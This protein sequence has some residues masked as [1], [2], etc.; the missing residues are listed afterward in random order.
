MLFIPGGSSAELQ[1][2][3]ISI[4][5]LL[6]HLIKEQAMQFFAESVCRDGA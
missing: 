6:K 4:Q 5:Q 3:D 2:A 1:T